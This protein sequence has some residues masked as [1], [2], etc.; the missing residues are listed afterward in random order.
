MAFVRG[1]SARAM[2]AGSALNVIGSMSTNTGVAPT[3]LTDPAVAKNENVGVI[4]S[5]PG[6]MPSAMSTASSAS[7]PDETVTA[8]ATPSMAANSASIA[9]TS[10][11]R[12][13]RWLSHT[14]VMAARIS[15]RMGAYC[16]VRSRS[17][18]LMAVAGEAG[19]FTITTPRLYPPALDG[20]PRFALA[21]PP[22]D[23]LAL[24]ELLLALRQRDRELDPALLEIHPQRDDRQAL[25]RRLAEQLV[26]FGLI[27]Q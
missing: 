18:T 1:V 24:V 2:A 11:P 15:S 4:T 13:K 20:G 9:S 7:V 17:G 19:G 16:A 22:A 27:Q 12:M 25:F 21:F 5:S 23:R 14:R 8:S 10:G 26:E 6:P 3:R